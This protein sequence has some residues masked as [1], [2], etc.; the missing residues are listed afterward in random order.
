M[1]LLDSCWTNWLYVTEVL[2]T[3][4]HRSLSASLPLLLFQLTKIILVLP[5]LVFSETNR[6]HQS[7][8]SRFVA[9]VPTCT[10]RIPVLP[11]DFPL[12]F[13]TLSLLSLSLSFSLF[14]V[15]SFLVILPS[16][17]RS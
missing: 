6:L 11:R 8:S 1:Y 2:L 13:Y 17:R 14:L 9:V 15:G 3:L 7:V 16:D 4:K 12:P 10:S 5:T